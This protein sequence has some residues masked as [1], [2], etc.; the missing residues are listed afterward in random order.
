MM[1]SKNE[2]HQLRKD[3]LNQFHMR[4]QPVCL[5]RLVQTTDYIIQVVII[6]INLELGEV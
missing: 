4:D 1:T 5:D 2:H 3:R 6:N